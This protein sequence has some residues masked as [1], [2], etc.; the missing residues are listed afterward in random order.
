MHTYTVT[1]SSVFGEG[2]TS[3]TYTVAKAVCTTNSGTI[4]L[5]PGLTGTAAYQG[6]K[7]KGTLTGCT[8]EPFTEAKYTASLTT[9]NKVTCSAMSGPGA[10]TFGTAK[11][12]WTPKTKATAGT[13]SMPLTETAGIALS[14]EL[15]SGPYSPASISG[16]V[17][18][19]YFGGV[20]CGIP[21]NGK[22]VKP[23]TKA[24]FTGSAVVFS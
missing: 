10:A 13:F 6:V 14:S 5:S 8:G 2:T 12:A 11:Y 18:E 4:T 7:I 24:T 21:V 16:T 15:E 1:A 20:T 23:V 9:T 3:I 22:P 19:G 17:R